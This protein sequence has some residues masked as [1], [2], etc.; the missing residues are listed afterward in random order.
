MTVL[1]GWVLQPFF[2]HLQRSR[3][4]SHQFAIVATEVFCQILK[5]SVFTIA[6]RQLAE[7]SYIF[8]AGGFRK[9]PGGEGTWWGRG[10]WASSINNILGRLSWFLSQVTLV[11]EPWNQE[12]DAFRMASWGGV[13][14]PFLYPFLLSWIF[15]AGSWRIVEKML[16]IHSMF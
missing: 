8:Q 5:A 15:V 14:Y 1:D 6:I 12:A 9:K 7:N 16:P 10:V 4:N 13:G 2:Q 11:S 3:E